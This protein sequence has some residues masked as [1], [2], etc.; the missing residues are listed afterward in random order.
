MKDWYKLKCLTEEIG[1]STVCACD[2]IISAIINHNLEEYLETQK[3]FINVLSEKPSIVK[4]YM[5]FVH[6]LK[7]L[8]CMPCVC[9]C[10]YV[11]NIYL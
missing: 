9:V 6:L 1:Q 10:V 7:S 8:L 4:L 11:S 2:N 3:M 5:Y